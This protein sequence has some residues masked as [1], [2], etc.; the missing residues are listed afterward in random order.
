MKGMGGD[1]FLLMGDADVVDG[2]YRKVMSS[3]CWYFV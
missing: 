1:S 2:A 3:F